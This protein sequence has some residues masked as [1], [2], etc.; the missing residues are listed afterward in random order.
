MKNGFLRLVR[1]GRLAFGVVLLACSAFALTAKA[2]ELDITPVAQETSEWCWAAS[3]EMVFTH[4]GVPNLNPGGNFQCAVVGAQ[5]GPCAANCALCLN[6]GGTTQRIAVV[7]R[8]Y[9]NFARAMTGYTNSDI[10]I[11]TH[12]ILSKSQIIKSIDDDAPIIAGVSPTGIAYP[13]G[14]GFSEHAVVIVGYEAGEGDND[15]LT[16]I[17]NDPFPPSVN[18]WL[19]A[20]AETTEPGQYKMS[21]ERFISRMRYGNSITFDP[22]L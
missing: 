20:G 22:N 16:L 1:A 4:Y 17:I 18:I 14:M 2:S 5:G 9:M 7:L 19:A 3:A 12:G 6:G 8:Q 11:R 21:Y 13:P 15:S 10:S